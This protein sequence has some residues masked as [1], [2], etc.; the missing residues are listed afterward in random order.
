MIL[1]VRSTRAYARA[2]L[3]GPRPLV[4][5][6]C[7]IGEKIFIAFLDELGNFKPFEKYFIFSPNWRPPIWRS[8]ATYALFEAL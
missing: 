2:F 5:R 1:K 4:V 3:D 6:K 8:G 7:Q